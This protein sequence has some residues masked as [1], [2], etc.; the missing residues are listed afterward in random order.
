MPPPLVPQ[1][2]S[3]P[4]AG[5]ATPES[6]EYLLSDQISIHA[7]REGGDWGCFGQRNESRNFNPRLPRGRRRGQGVRP[8]QQL[9]ISILAPREGGDIASN[10]GD[11]EHL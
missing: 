4:P 7:S 10:H 6:Y 9:K 2:Q 1:F 11:P 8:V 5:E 3:T